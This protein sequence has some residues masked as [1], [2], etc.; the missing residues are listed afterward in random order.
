MSSQTR[1]CDL[2]LQ[3]EH[4]A[5]TES[6]D[7]LLKSLTTHLGKTFGKDLYVSFWVADEAKNRLLLAAETG[8]IG[9]CIE[10]TDSVI[11]IGQGLVGKAAAKK[12]AICG[13]ATD[14]NSSLIAPQFA[15]KNS[16]QS[17]VAI[18]LLRGERVAG[19]VFLGKRGYFSWKDEMGGIERLAR[20]S[21]V[22]LEEARLR[23]ESL[24]LHDMARK[25]AHDRADSKTF[26]E[27]LIK[28][29][30]QYFGTRGCSLLAFKE[31]KQALQIISS[32]NSN[33]VGEC[34][35]FGEGLT[36]YVAKERTVLR[37]LQIGSQE[38]HASISRSLDWA[39][40]YSDFQ[41]APDPK[42]HFLAVPVISDGHSDGLLGILRVTRRAD[43]PPFFPYEEDLLLAVSHQLTPIMKLDA[44]VHD[45]ERQL[46][47]ITSVKQEIDGKTREEVLDPILSLAI[48]LTG[49]DNGYIAVPNK[50]QGLFDI[51][52][53]HQVPTSIA[54]RPRP[55]ESGVIGAAY[56]RNKT[57]ICA[58]HNDRKKYVEEP[59][60]LF[61]SEIA[62]VLRE[63]DCPFAIINLHSTSDNAFSSDDLSMVEHLG[64]VSLTA[65]R[66]FERE[67]GRVR[68]LLE[69]LQQFQR[70]E[71]DSNNRLSEVLGSILL[72]ACS[73]FDARDAFF[74]SESF[75]GHARA[76]ASTFPLA[77]ES[78]EAIVTF[79]KTQLN[80]EHRAVLRPWSYASDLSLFSPG[81]AHLI[82]KHDLPDTG[83]AYVSFLGIPSAFVQDEDS[84]MLSDTFVEVLAATYTRF[85]VS[86]RANDLQRVEDRANI[87][88]QLDVVSLGFGHEARNII[89]NTF[90]VVDAALDDRSDISDTKAQDLQTIRESMNSL[91]DL[92]NK[93]LGYS[94]PRQ[95]SYL[96]VGDIVDVASTLMRKACKE[97]NVA[98]ETK[99]PKHVRGIKKKFRHNTIYADESTILQVITNLITNA[100]AAK[101]GNSGRIE[102]AADTGIPENKTG[103]WALI[104]VKDFGKGIAKEK[105][106][107]IWK[108]GFTTKDD[109]YGL[110]LHIV[111]RLVLEHGGTIELESAS[112]RGACFRIWFPIQSRKE[113]T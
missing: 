13:N 92:V 50:D 83:S 82:Y 53:K 39:K 45:Q 91:T 64:S 88:Q 36:G 31:R 101:K 16:L 97:A 66:E 11:R 106:N 18:P 63:R 65:A 4:L 105:Q 3:I 62:V 94:R 19:V 48:T 81:S 90:A 25:C 33:I 44:L 47:V 61:S 35:D 113:R 86:K 46:R 77:D 87:G 22:L 110:G 14:D 28:F 56:K 72:E 95:N 37:L 75:N 104:E 107:D 32:T 26:F 68:V 38:E 40:K 12:T 5:A 111:R 6:V 78:V 23:E 74:I 41:D 67:R 93:F 96:H 98:L 84:V 24:F 71:L 69:S 80:G 100:I 55:L 52:A 9:S 57:I 51:V 17:V 27:D 21:A 7:G 109:G 60:E 43:D 73:Q 20:A 54:E 103:E 58:N 89:N 10:E 15:G 34:Y 70:C 76:E 2:C 108:A 30:A 85:V 102:I 112:N 59:S 8:G 42:D 29:I 99:I 49:A 1:T 79:C